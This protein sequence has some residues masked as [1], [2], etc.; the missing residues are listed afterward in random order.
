MTTR[1]AT[2]AVLAATATAF[3]VLTPATATAAPTC[4]GGKDNFCIEITGGR[5]GRPRATFTGGGINRWSVYY[6]MRDATGTLVGDDTFA[7]Y[8]TERTFHID[9]NSNHYTLNARACG[10]MLTKVC[11]H[12][13]STSWNRP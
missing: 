13:I 3:V 10:G 6:T 9:G 5:E 11:S 7:I 1:P 12:T 4:T 2:A 8:G